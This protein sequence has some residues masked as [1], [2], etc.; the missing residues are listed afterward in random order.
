MAISASAESAEKINTPPVTFK[1]KKNSFIKE[2]K[3]VVGG[4]PRF[5]MSRYY[6]KRI[7]G[8]SPLG[9]KKK[10]GILGKVG[11]FDVQLTKGIMIRDILFISAIFAPLFVRI[12]L[13]LPGLTGAGIY[14]CIWIYLYTA[15]RTLGKK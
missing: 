14:V 4:A 8:N 12:R 9:R 7:R 2:Y 6:S 13:E 1:K 15:R 3:F 5:L 11:A 10:G